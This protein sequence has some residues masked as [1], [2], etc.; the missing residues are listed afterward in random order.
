MHPFIKNMTTIALAVVITGCANQSMPGYQR[1]YQGHQIPTN[2]VDIVQKRLNA[3]GLKQATVSVDTVGR[4]RLT[5]TYRDEDEVERA[6]I[7]AQSIV[8][9]Q[10]TSPFYPEKVQEKRWEREAGNAL[11]DFFKRKKGFE[12]LAGAFEKRRSSF[13]WAIHDGVESIAKAAVPRKDI[14]EVLISLPSV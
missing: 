8:G 11:G 9:I 5:G 12:D 7:I 1:V 3:E 13:S 2:L 6:F 4:L 10:S 14:R